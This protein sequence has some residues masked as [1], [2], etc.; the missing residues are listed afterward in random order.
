[1]KRAGLMSDAKTLGKV[2]SGQKNLLK[3][4]AEGAKM[5]LAGRTFLGEADFNL[6]F[7][8]EGASKAGVDD[9]FRQLVEA[10]HEAGIAVIIDIVPNHM[11]FTVHN[12]WL[13]D[14]LANGPDSRYASHFDIFWES[15]PAGYPQV[16]VPE[17][18]NDLVTELI[19][20]QDLRLA[21][22][23]FGLDSVIFRPH[24]VYGARQNIA[25]RYRNVI[26]IFMNQVLRGEPMTIY[27][28]GMQT[29][30]FSDVADVAPI[31][32]RSVERPEAYGEVINVGADRPY[33]VRAMAEALGRTA[34]NSKY[35]PDL[36]MHPVL[37]KKVRS[38]GESTENR[39]T[40]QIGE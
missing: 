5:A 9:A 18:G 26:G 13:R 22:E 17:L 27:G 2:V 36:D 14:V 10:F 6:H 4:V 20:R 8:T 32:A 7:V 30:A 35:S 38:Q 29:R 31:I 34:P 1:M 3:G 16:L 21:R 33:T 11:A 23:Q 37:G 25:D 15:G 40:W 19:R 24:N 39:T 28:D 12:V